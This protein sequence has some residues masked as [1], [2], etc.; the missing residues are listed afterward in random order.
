LTSLS[1]LYNQKMRD[2]NCTNNLLVELNVF[3]NNQLE[4]LHCNNNKLTKMD[5]SQNLVLNVFLCDGNPD[6]KKICIPKRQKVLFKKHDEY[7][8]V[9]LCY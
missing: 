7:D 2:L 5:L 9:K 1:L 8:Y 4:S 6:L 3:G